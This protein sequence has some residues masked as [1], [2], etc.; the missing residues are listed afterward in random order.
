MGKDELIKGALR[1]EIRIVPRI[2]TLEVHQ[3]GPIHHMRL[4]LVQGMNILTDMSGGGTGKTTILDCAA[5]VATGLWPA[6]HQSSLR[7]R[8]K[9]IAEAGGRVYIFEPNQQ[10]ISA[11]PPNRSDGRLRLP[12]GAR[13]IHSLRRALVSAP[14]HSLV[15]A[16]GGIL[17]VLDH[18][19]LR[20]AVQSLAASP[21]Q[22]LVVVPEPLLGHFTG[23]PCRLFTLG[24]RYEIAYCTC[25]NL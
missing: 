2:D 1:E 10:E 13:A 3:A 15:L 21:S 6:G 9:I 8:T 7:P 14:G 5:A 12:V 16:D 17:G 19:R 24:I 22:K 25:F 20:Q 23:I 4:A 11:D 18:S